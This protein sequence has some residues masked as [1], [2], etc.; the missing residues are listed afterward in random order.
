MAAATHVLTHSKIRVPRAAA[1]P[2]A[3]KMDETPEDT[4]LMLRYRDGDVV[5]VVAD[6]L[7][8]AEGAARRLRDP[9]QLD[10][11]V[12]VVGDRL[13]DEHVGAGLERGLRLL[14]VQ[15]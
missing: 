3:L 12:E 15:L 11:L 7:A 4:A 10:R 5:A 6:L 13:G 14:V 8:D 9:D 1:V 2:Y